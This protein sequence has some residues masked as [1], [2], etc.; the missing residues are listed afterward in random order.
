MRQLGGFRHKT[1]NG[2]QNVC[3][4]DVDCI[5]QA[6]DTVQWWFLEKLQ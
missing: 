6:L 1:E 4:K 5:Y 2:F 3:S